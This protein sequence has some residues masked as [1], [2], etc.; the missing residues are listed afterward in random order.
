MHFPRDEAL[1]GELSTNSKDVIHNRYVDMDD[2]AE[3]E[4]FGCAQNAMQCYVKSQAVSDKSVADCVE[5]FIGTYLLSGG[6]L[7]AVKFL[8]WMRILPAQDNFAQLLYKSIPTV[9]SENKATVADV[10]FL[11]N[12]SRKDIEQILQYKFKDPSYL[13]EAMSH[14]S[15][16]RNRLT[17][18]YE[19]LEFL[20]D[21]ILDFLITAHIFEN[22]EELK[23][24]DLTDL[25]S[26]L[27]NNVTFASYVVK[28]GI[29]KHLCSQLNP[30][31][32]CAIIAFVEHQEQRDHE[33]I[34][35]VLYL[36]EEDECHLAEYVEVPKVLS[37]IFESLIGGIYLD[38]G[39][40]LQIVWSVIYRIMWK[41]IDAFSK[42]IPKQPV[43]VLHEKMHACPEF[44]KPQMTDSDVP[45]VMVPVTIT[46]NGKRHTVYGFGNNKFQAKRAAA[47]MAL[48][49]LSL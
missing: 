21:A 20:G 23:P 40:D 25:R 16:I 13:L 28:L 37:D 33:I 29:Y 34:E 8:E 6:V 11:L 1:Q 30:T 47:K 10:E 36:I 45:K 3:E 18:S 44:G 9:L 15:Y 4:P 26:A 22:S 43:R 46:K 24:G 27:V 35:D 41:E 32:D 17:R 31:L 7:G 48:K 12:S 39:G 14:P 49:I 5:A 42:I 2:A 19:R 38:C